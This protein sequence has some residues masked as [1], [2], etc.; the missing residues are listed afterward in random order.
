MLPSEDFCNLGDYIDYLRDEARVGAC[1]VEVNGGAQFRRLMTEV[2]IFLRFSEIAVETKKRDVIQARGVALSSLEWRDVVAK[3]LS[4]EAHLPLQ[5]RVLYVGERLRWFFERQKEAVVEFMDTLEGTPM[6]NMYSALYPKHVKLIKNNEMIRH[7]VYQTYDATCERQLHL[8]VDLFDNVLTSTFANPWVF[9]K[10][11][12]TGDEDTQDTQLPS[13][14]DT[15]DRIPTEIAG[16]SS[17]EGTLT[18]WLSEI[19]VEPER[20]DE[21]VD[22]VQMLLTR[23]YG[24]IRSK[25]CDQVELFAESFFKLPML[26]RLEEDMSGIDLSEQDKLN[27]TARRDRLEGERSK[28]QVYLT[29]VNKCVDRLQGFIL[30]SG[31]KSA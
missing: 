10:G 7:L 9:L 16:R 26:R 27:C 21:A 14:E 2:E 24:F 20:V 13:F 28:N 31:A 3:L 23:A 5:Q 15:K 12:T 4:N 29:E 6:G 11:A 25:V 19:P 17:V 30:A 22:R 8:F 18:T 1:D